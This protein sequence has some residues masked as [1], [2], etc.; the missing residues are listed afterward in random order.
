M[1]VHITWTSASSKLF[2]I[3]A[4]VSYNTHETKEYTAVCSIHLRSWIFW[5]FISFLIWFYLDPLPHSVSISYSFKLR[6]QQTLS[7]CSAI[8]AP[9]GISRV[10][11]WKCW[12]MKERRLCWKLCWASSL[13][14][15][16]QCR[17]PKA[18]SL[19]QVLGVFSITLGINLCDPSL[20]LFYNNRIIFCL[21]YRALGR[22][23]LS[24]L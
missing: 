11:I 12:Q 20:C 10:W 13:I 18:K 4:F 16:L 21:L 3:T 5:K 17:L 8:Y 9:V 19:L 7:V 6:K 24:I 1:H 22:I 23:R 2:P 14:W 15:L